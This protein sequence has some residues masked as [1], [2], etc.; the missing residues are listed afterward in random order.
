VRKEAELQFAKTRKEEKV[1]FS[2]ARKR[3]GFSLPMREKIQ[4]NTGLNTEVFN[5]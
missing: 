4:W 5:G 3:E 1:Q 2:K